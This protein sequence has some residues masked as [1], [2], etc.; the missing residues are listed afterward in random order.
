MTSPTIIY[1]FRFNEMPLFEELKSVWLDKDNK[2]IPLFKKVSL[3][4]H[5][6]KVHPYWSI[7]LILTFMAVTFLFITSNIGLHP[8]NNE[9]I[10]NKQ[11]VLYKYNSDENKILYKNIFG[12]PKITVKSFIEKNSDILECFTDAED[13]VVYSFDSNNR[14]IIEVGCSM[15]GYKAII[16]RK[17]K[18]LSFQP[19]S[20][21]ILD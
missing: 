2:Q 8:V 15:S 21:G 10:K 9:Y 16:N 5:C 11:E 12:I 6:F 18:I 3:T 19:H 17:G 14:A 13:Y 7:I 1:E 20:I 4:Y